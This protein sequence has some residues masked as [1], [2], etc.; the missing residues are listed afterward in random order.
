MFSVMFHVDQEP[1]AP[2][3]YHLLACYASPICTSFAVD[4][5][6]SSFIVTCAQGIVLFKQSFC[7]PPM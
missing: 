5:R 4:G 6:A 1:S 3:V 7:P 2:S